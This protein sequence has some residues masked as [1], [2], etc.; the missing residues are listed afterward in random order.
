MVWWAC[1]FVLSMLARYEPDT[2][3]QLID[4]DQS[5]W[6]VHIETFLGEALDIVPDLIQQLRSTRLKGWPRSSWACPW[7]RPWPG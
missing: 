6:A 4:P 1:L 2:W 7:P 5:E 3:V